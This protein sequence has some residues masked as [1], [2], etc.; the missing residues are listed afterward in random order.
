MQKMCIFS[1]KIVEISYILNSLELLRE[2]LSQKTTLNYPLELCLGAV[3]LV[4]QLRKL[5]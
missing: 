4:A 3:F 1:S 2:Y 5:F